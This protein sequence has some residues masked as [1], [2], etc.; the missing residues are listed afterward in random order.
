TGLSLP[1]SLIGAFFLMYMMGFTINVMT[2]LALSL[3][4]GL[5][6]DDA[7]VVRENIF[8][9]AEMGKNPIRAASD[10]TKAVLMAVIATTMAVIAVFGPMGF[11]AGVVGQFFKEFA[12]TVCFAMAI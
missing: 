9:H 5:L 3:A 7:I 11:L 1:T 8:R 4:V 10:G 2:L 6:I 12:L